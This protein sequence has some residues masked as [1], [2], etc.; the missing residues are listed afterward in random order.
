MKDGNLPEYDVTDMPLENI[1]DVICDITGLTNM[2]WNLSLRHMCDKNDI[3]DIVYS[4][5][6]PKLKI[7]NAEWISIKTSDD[8]SKILGHDQ[9]EYINMGLN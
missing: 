6:I 3:R 8:T 9:F 4:L 2:Y 7:K 5:R 1:S